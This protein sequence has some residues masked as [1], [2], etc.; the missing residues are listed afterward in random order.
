[1]D[2][3]ITEGY[4]KENKPKIEVIRKSRHNSPVC[5]KN[6]HVIA[7]VTDTTVN[8]TVPKFGFDDV[9]GLAD[10]IEKNFLQTKR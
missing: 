3:I 4:K 9:K 5:G 7:V 6:D 10:L 8:L 2:L 1:M